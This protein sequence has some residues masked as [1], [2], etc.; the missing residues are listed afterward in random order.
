MRVLKIKNFCPLQGVYITLVL[1]LMAVI[2]T[3]LPAQ[4]ANN[5]SQHSTE[6]DDLS[7]VKGT[8]LAQKT[9]GAPAGPLAITGYEIRRITFPTAKEINLNGKIKRVHAVNRVRVYGKFQAR[10]LVAIVCIN[11]VATVGSESEDLR[12]VVAFTDDDTL[13]KNGARIAV[14]YGNPDAPCNALG[15]YSVL[16]EKLKIGESQ[17]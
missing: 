9:D 16:P 14:G 15:S 11:N 3:A 6:G 4:P 7:K 2:G 13:F 1:I 10:A 17:K 5:T 8:L 12:S